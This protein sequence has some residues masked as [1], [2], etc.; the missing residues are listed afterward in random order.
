M[1]NCGEEE[2]VE[3]VEFREVIN[4]K[5]KLILTLLKIRKQLQEKC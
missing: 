3:N 1:L 2:V 5:L 4:Q